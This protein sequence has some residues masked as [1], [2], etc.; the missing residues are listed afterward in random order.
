MLFSPEDYP[1]DT[2]FYT[3]DGKKLYIVSFEEYSEEE[4][5]YEETFND[6]E[7]LISYSKDYEDSIFSVELK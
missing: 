1:G 5:D 4:A 3:P 6:V 2:C 7:S